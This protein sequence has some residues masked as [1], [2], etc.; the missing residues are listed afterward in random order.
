[1]SRPDPIRDRREAMGLVAAEAGRARSGSGRLVLLRGAT[2]TGRSTLLEAAA[3]HAEAHGMRV[4]RVRC[5]AHSIAPL[6]AVTQLLRAGPDF[7]CPA[8]ASPETPDAAEAT[9]RS[10]HASQLWRELLALAAEKPLLLAVD[11][12]HLADAQSRNW[13]M[14]AARQLDRIPVLLV[15]T[16]R[17]QY[18]VEPPLSG[19]A[20]AL[21]PALVRTRTLSPLAPDTAAELVRSQVGDAPPQ[22]WVDD[23][24]RA[25]AGNPLLLRALLDDLRTAEPD[26]PRPTALPDTC[27]ALYPGSYPAAVT[28]W[29]DSAGSATAEVARALAAMDEDSAP[30]TVNPSATDGPSAL[31]RGDDPARG[32]DGDP[33]LLAGMTG[34]DPARVHGWLTAM[35]HLGMLRPA[36]DGRLRYAHPLLRDAVLSGWSAA[37]RQQAHRLAAEAMLRRGDPAEA[38]AGQL[39]R[40]PEVGESWATRILLDAAAVTVRESRT[41]DAVAF[42]RRALDEPMTSARRAE[43]LTELGSLEFASALPAVGIPRLA[44]ALQ[45]ASS[46]EGRVRT[47][48]ALGTALAGQGEARAAVNVLRSL[49]R[50]LTDHPDLVGTLQTASAL[51]ADHDQQVRRRMYG[52][53]RERAEHSPDLIGAAGQALLVRYESTAGLLSAHAAMDRVRT[54]LKEPAEPLGESFL[55]GTTAAIA[56]WADELD[57]AE[58][59]VDRGLAGQSTSLLH[60]M[61]AALLNVRADI[62]AARGSYAELLAD[63]AVLRAPEAHDGRRAPTNAHAHAVVALVDTGRV[64]EART[65]AGAFDLRD[66]PDSWE[67]NRFLYARGVLRAADGD[68]AGARDDFLECGRR[69]AARSVVSPAVTPWRTAA[70]ECELALGRPEQALALAEEELRLASVWNT[71]RQIGRA[72]RVLGAATGGRHGLELTDQAVRQL[73]DAPAE[74]ELIMAL[75]DQGRLLTAV[76]ERARARDPLREAAERAERKGAVRLLALA[77]GVLREGGAR[78]TTAAHTGSAALTASERRITALAADGRTNTEIARLLHLARRTVETHLTS[79]YRKLG[80]R[81]R[82]ELP[83]AL[84]RR[85]GDAERPHRER[86]QRE[87][88]R[89]EQ[90]HRDQPHRELPAW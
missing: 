53:L 72:L 89:R 4:L 1:M 3:E 11:D 38:V 54:L 63:P 78:R 70:A 47:A 74:T 46:P 82:G 65:L 60:P 7:K 19:L 39:L 66:A 64:D 15:A 16:E 32:A 68:T 79:S 18:D 55:L 41:G 51:L 87:H 81:R 35:T 28:W 56:Q 45:L 37:R 33:V 31:S 80:I 22:A 13:L 90:P 61:H 52:W 20:H 50:Q 69:Q 36:P 76:G 23:C 26:G 84:A 17:S 42:L 67:P 49:D 62:A 30:G 12:I 24:V 21:S 40:V 2:G 48:V 9:R 58:R 10:D 34:A 85:P 6:T 8:Q 43:V 83:A 14:A 5:T 71:P 57:E 88:P 29:L 86:V 44:Q 25:A 77:E 73:R 59:L 27:A 75:I